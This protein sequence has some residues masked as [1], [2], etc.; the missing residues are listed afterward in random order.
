MCINEDFRCDC[1]NDCSDGS[2]ELIS[3][4][5]CAAGHEATCASSA[6]GNCYRS[7]GF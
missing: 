1:V 5:L 7:T 2:D 3:W 4:A 6:T